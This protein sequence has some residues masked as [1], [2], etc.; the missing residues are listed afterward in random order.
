[1]NKVLSRYAGVAEALA[2]LEA[3]KWKMGPGFAVLAD[4]REIASVEFGLDGAYVIAG[5]T[6][7]GVVYHTNHYLEPGFA[8]LNKDKASRSSLKRYARIGELLAARGS[9]AADDFRRYGADA[10]LWRTGTRPTTTRT[11]ASWIIRQAP[12]GTA[13]LY[14]RLANPGKAPAEYEFTVAALFA[15]RVDLTKV[16]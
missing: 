12:D 5:R 13:V 2:A 16:E 11:R 6:T 14:L 8:A 3:G 7:S 9:H 15:G 1:L 10:V 4:G